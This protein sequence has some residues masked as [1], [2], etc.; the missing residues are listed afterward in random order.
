VIVKDAVRRDALYRKRCFVKATDATGDRPAGY[1]GMKRR[2]SPSASQLFD[3]GA[4]STETIARRV[5][6]I[7]TGRCTPAE[8]HKMV[9]EKIVA[10]G[11]SWLQAMMFPWTGAA[12]MIEP[13][14]RAAR[15]NARRLRSKS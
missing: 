7:A 15:R 5:T 11:H 9:T 10:A 1:V 2:R 13:Y 4:A 3:L 14:R 6:L 8:Y 12:A